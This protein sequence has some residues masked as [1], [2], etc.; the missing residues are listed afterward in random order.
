MRTTLLPTRV[1][2]R[3]GPLVLAL[4][5]PLGAVLIGQNAPLIVAR[6][7]QALAESGRAA[8]AWEARLDEM[9]RAGRLRLR[10]SVEDTM[11]PGRVHD[12][13]EQYAGEARILGAEVVRQRS[14][15]GVA[16]VF[17]E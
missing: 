5:F 16:S 13:F 8:A 3:L 14:A 6:A 12:R 17:G 4:C 11:I 9:Q 7:P 2:P 1:R 10:S 15:D